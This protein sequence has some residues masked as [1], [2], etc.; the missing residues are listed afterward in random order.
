MPP[1]MDVRSVPASEMIRQIVV[2]RLEN[3][4]Y[5]YTDVLYYKD[6]NRFSWPKIAMFRSQLISFYVSLRP[7]IED[8]T[9]QI[10]KAA[11]ENEGIDEFTDAIIEEYRSLTTFMDYIC[12]H[13]SEFTM[14][15]MNE[16]Y[17]RLVQ[18]CEDYN[19]TRTTMPVASS[20]RLE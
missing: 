13:P 3:L 14:F 9:R 12:G 2:K 16:I 4:D 18:F 20:G 1:Y 15:E 11:E 19:L 10:K 7:K 8:Y 17:K 5:L 6:M